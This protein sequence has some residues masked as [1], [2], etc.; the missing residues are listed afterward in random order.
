[1]NYQCKKCKK[2]FFDDELDIKKKK[3]VKGVRVV[4]VDYYWKCE[5]CGEKNFIK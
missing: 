1:M 2:Y 4:R 5:K 3:I